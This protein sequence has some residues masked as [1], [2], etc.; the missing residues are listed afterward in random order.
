MGREAKIKR[1]TKETVIDLVLKL[2]GR[3]KPDINT[4]VGFF[5]HMLT[6]LAKHSGW[7]LTVKAKGDLEVDDHHTVED[8]GLCLGTAL[9]EALGDKAGIQRFASTS[10][11]MDETLANAAADISGRPWL[12]YQVDYGTDKI[13]EFD[14]QLVQ[15]F[16]R[17]V[18]NTAGLTLHINVPYG[19]NSHHIAE[20]IFKAVAQ[21]LGQASRITDKTGQIP[22]TKGSL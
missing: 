1:Q 15:E 16:F 6:H 22:S 19:T 13:G 3:G 11:P 8:V 5:D 14:V 12:V 2:D 20:A 10:V 18:V 7:D 4:G 21:A 17:A 9:K